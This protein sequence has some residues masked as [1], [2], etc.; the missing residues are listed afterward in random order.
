[1]IS[2][3]FFQRVEIISSTI[4]PLKNMTTQQIASR[5][6][7]LCRKGD[8]ERAQNE[9]YAKD[10]VSIEA[11]EMPGFAKETKG[12]DA[13][14]KKG[15]LFQSMVE[16]VHGGNVSEPLVAGNT[17]AFVMTLDVTMKGQKRSKSDELCLYQVKD[18]KIVSEQ[19][20]V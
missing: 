8:Y 15:E 18:G 6:V 4:N 11:F 19:F 13:I 5:L 7:E 9:L 20:F 1:M 17:I 16:Q 14:K 3:S 10:A 12:L 2:T